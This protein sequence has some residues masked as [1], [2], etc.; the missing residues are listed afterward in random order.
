MMSEFESYVSDPKSPIVQSGSGGRI[1]GN[2]PFTRN[3]VIRKF[4]ECQTSDD[5][6]RQ[7]QKF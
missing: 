6:L 3:N 4:A 5:Q 1:D 2:V 7:I